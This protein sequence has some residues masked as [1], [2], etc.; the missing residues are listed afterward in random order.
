MMNNRNIN[1]AGKVETISTS[2]KINQAIAAVHER[3]YL[4]HQRLGALEARLRAMS[5]SDV[6]YVSING[7]SMPMPRA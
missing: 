7:I 3:R 1:A 4:A 2:R 6:S 5:N